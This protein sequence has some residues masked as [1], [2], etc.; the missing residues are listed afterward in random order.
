M[1]LS[2]LI[3]DGMVL[4]RNARTAIW[5]SVEREERVRIR[6]LGRTYETRA[7][8][9]GNWKIVMENL[10]AGGPH[11]LYI[12]ADGEE[13]I[14]RD[15]MVGDVWLLGGQSNMELPVR[16][17]LDRLEDEV[18]EVDLPSIRQFS[19]P[20]H[21][22]FAGPRPDV[23]EG[24]W[25]RAVGQDVMDFSGV[26]FFFA[27][28]LYEKYG[29]PIG[30]IRTAVGG[31]PIEAWLSEETI[32]QYPELM[33][34]LERCKDESYVASVIRSD[35][36]RA[37]RWYARLNEQDQG[38][39]EGWYLPDDDSAAW[40]TFAVPDS[41]QGSELEEVRGSVWFRRTFEVPASMAGCEA[42]LLLGTIVDAD[43]TY[44]NG[45]LVGRTAYRYPPRRYP[46]PA[47][48]LKEGLNTIAVRVLS[49]RHTG[50]FIRDMPYRIRANGQEIGLEGVWRYRIGAMAD[51]LPEQTFFQWKPC[52][53]FNG[54]IA[55]LRQYALSGVLW[56][57]GESNTH[58]PLGYSGLFQ[59]LA[60]DWRA[61]FGRGDLP[62]IYAQLPNFGPEAIYQEDSR[63]AVLRHEQLRC[64]A[65][66]GTAMAVTI[67]V[68]EHNDLHPQ[69]KKTVGERMARCAMRLVYGEDIL[70]SGPIY[71][72]MEIANDRI[73]IRFDHV[74]GGLVARGGDPGGF[75]ICGADGRF[76][77]ARAAIAGEQ[78]IVWHEQ[79][80]APVH[81]RYAWADNPADAN[82]Y[83]A[84]GLPASPFTTEES[85]EPDP[86][87]RNPS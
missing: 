54:M 35:E 77:P 45:T 43:D 59:H 14:I 22:S 36:A 64:L 68:G 8:A 44:V 10:P 29:V 75:A 65:T 49:V 28:A 78:V 87:R 7:D 76:L 20:L 60:R 51:E 84:E 30:L 34:E 86:E 6:F 52:G 42:K 21:V 74:G 50:E 25:I 66:S 5:G 12:S 16:R 48:V 38:L 23:T 32:R 9:Q 67:D 27:R 70:S 18:R 53:L 47:G 3:S 15:V 57:Q 11:E 26:G 17:T 19:V 85:L 63:W 56:Y 62:I 69:D 4:Q 61:I 40:R 41:W 31:S 37:A 39:K 1:R 79:I 24:N 33:E 2:A 82:L 46:L 13:R 72:A 73:H 58:Q 71:K 83:N 80:H 55:P 81:V